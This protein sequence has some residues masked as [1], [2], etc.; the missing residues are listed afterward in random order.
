MSLNFR[1]CPCRANYRRQKVRKKSA[2]HVICRP[3]IFPKAFRSR[4]RSLGIIKAARCG[5][6]V[7][8]E[9]F[10][11]LGGGG[12]FCSTIYSL[13][14]SQLLPCLSLQRRFNFIVEDKTGGCKYISFIPSA[15]SLHEGQR[16]TVFS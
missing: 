2:R 8:I 11:G 9:I 3:D 13:R 15:G 12:L 10:Q 14:T 6:Q 4:E 5:A 16:G 1:V 7:P